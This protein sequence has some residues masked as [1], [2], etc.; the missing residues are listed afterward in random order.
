MWPWQA[1]SFQMSQHPSPGS[2][3]YVSSVVGTQQACSVPMSAYSIPAMAHGNG[4]GQE[5]AVH[6]H[7]AGMGIG[8]GIAAGTAA[9]AATGSSQLQSVP[10]TATPQV[11][12][13]YQQ[14]LQETPPSGQVGV[15]YTHQAPPTAMASP[16]PTQAYIRHATPPQA[17][18]PHGSSRF[19][20]DFILGDKTS[21]GM[22]PAVVPTFSEAEK[23]EL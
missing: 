19:S 16:S 13:V 22:A 8:Y 4:A 5:Y 9:V 17:T 20:M 1:T 11:G 23:S 12:V 2:A 6:S 15:A 21:G 18:P 10:D 14:G 7:A 3:H